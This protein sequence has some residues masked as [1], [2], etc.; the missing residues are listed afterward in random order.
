MIC[1]PTTS[2]CLTGQVHPSI[3]QIENPPSLISSF[4]YLAQPTDG[5]FCHQV[6]FLLFVFYPFL[7]C[8]NMELIP[9]NN[10]KNIQALPLFIPYRWIEIQGLQ[11]NPI[12]LGTRNLFIYL[13]I[14]GKRIWLSPISLG[15]H[16]VV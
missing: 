2:V 7:V 11:I 9:L 3:S 8:A 14:V 16:P 5:I 4:H 1:P 12:F 6:G 13:F 15:S 10:H